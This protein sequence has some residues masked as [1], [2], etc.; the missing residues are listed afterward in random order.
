M[1]ES[2][3]A[4]SPRKAFLV[5]HTHWDREWYL[6]FHRF[7]V[8]L[9]EVVD[10]VLDTLDHDPDFEHFVLDGQ[11][12]VLEDYL[13]VAPHQRDRVN[14]LVR[15]G[16]LSV[17]PWYI[18]PD[19]FLVSGEAT[20]RN[21]MFGR[22]G[23]PL[24][25]VQG[26]GYMPDSFGH[27][28]QMPQILQLT[29]LDSFIFTRGMGAEADDPGWIFRWAAPDGSEVL[30]VNQCDGYC[31]A[32]GLGFAEIWHAHTMRKTDPALAVAKV[33]EL[34]EKM[35][36]RAGGDPALLNNGCDHF[37]APQDF[38]GMLA[39]L[40]EAWP[41][42]EFTHGSF[43][44]FLRSIRSET[45][46]DDRPLVTGELLGG[47]DHL[48]LSGVWSARMPLKQQNEECQNLLT[49]YAEPMAAAA[50]FQHGRPW[51]G[52]LFDA[53]WKELLRNHPHDSIC[54]CST[55]S[56]HQDMETRF[57][58]VRQTGEQYLSRLMNRL[59]P[60]FAG[61][62]KDDRATVIGVA[63]P[64]PF[65]RDEVVER[66][67]ILQPVGYDLDNLRLLDEAGQAVPFEIIGRRFLERFWGIDYRAELFCND[68]L[69]LLDTYLR[70]FGD[71]IIGTEKDVDTK[72]CFLHIRFLARNLPAV[73]HVQY[74]L[75]DDAPQSSPAVLTDPVSSRLSADGAALENQHI[76][77]T[78]HPDGTFDLEDK[79]TGH[80]YS[81]LN[82][83]EDA[84][85]IG[86]EY[87]YC[88]AEINGLFF[89]GGCEGKVKLGGRSELAVTAETT[90][91]FDLPRSVE[92]D[93]KS[94]HPRTTPTDV[95]V[96]LTLRTGSHRVDIETDFN[97]RAF[98]HRLRT[99]FPT[100][101]QV[102]EVVSD[103]H[104]M[105]NTRPMTRPSG[106]DWDQ[107]APPTWP[108]QDFSFL[109]DKQ[110]GLA[111]FNRGL[112][113]FETFADHDGGIIFALTLLRSVDWLSRDDFPTRRNMNAGPTLHT[114][115]AQCIG[116]HTFRYSVMP[117]AGDS[118]AAD[119]KGESDRYRV[120][121]PTHQG[122]ADGM[123]AGGGSLVR[124]TNSRVAI[125]AI[126]KAER[127]NLLVVRMYNQADVPVT[128]TLHFES[129]VLDAEKINLL[130]GPLWMD[131]A[132]PAVT[133]GGLRLQV[134]LAPCEIATVAIAFD[135][136]APEESP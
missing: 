15:E 81:G 94:R 64:L 22:R 103:G 79:A 47:R 21:L 20:V 70:R 35:S 5:S 43:E 95:T 1:R 116:R 112:P 83:L 132:E 129:P 18:L 7:R 52:G 90:F 102:D 96:R 51:P 37:P 118:F 111:I 25:R 107:P 59:T 108:Q 100:G 38:G 124:K 60:M 126:K 136:L 61:Q 123:I 122:V 80:R 86:D 72:D 110:A 73:G 36:G 78:L 106:E 17:G 85:D 125:T 28:A 88:P 6:T 2:E 69:D 127:G 30:A 119:L 63:N 62:E 97:N 65:V 75:V 58:A 32:G 3:L 56:V 53:A 71:R 42:T 26:V 27:L 13:E 93:R 89:A 39:A 74:R 46:D 48:I 101:L 134:P 45:P 87:D 8:N 82:L 10:G 113:E 23:A 19:E 84:E 29:G 31:N 76:R 50:V 40:R 130:E 105:L 120:P 66:L 77:A 104:F 9:V 11:T 114:P 92:R 67:V 133:H 57:A 14:R 131:R 54:G 115:E 12:A 16:R 128:E 121:P 34:F 55:D 33:K 49:R 41:D 44:D 24:R 98:D 109:Q 4:P 91:R 135:S 68:Q 99:W 117:F